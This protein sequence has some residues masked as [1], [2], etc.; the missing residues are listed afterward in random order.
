MLQSWM[1]DTRYSKHQIPK[2]STS[3]SLQLRSGQALS[4]TEGT[5]EGFDILCSL[6]DNNQSREKC[7]YVKRVRALRITICERKI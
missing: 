6:F 3:L 4:P 5:I 2:F 7:L 1:L